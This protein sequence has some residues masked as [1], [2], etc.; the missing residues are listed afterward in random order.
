MIAIVVALG[1]NESFGGLQEHLAVPLLPL[2]DKPF[3]QHVVEFVANHEVRDFHFILSHLPEKIEEALGDGVRWGCKFRYHLLPG[4]GDPLRLAANIA[5]TQQGAV[6]LATAEC[7]PDFDLPNT[8][9]GTRIA[10]EGTWTRWAVLDPAQFGQPG[11]DELPSVEAGAFLSIESGRDFLR[12]Q[13]VA[14]ELQFPGLLIAGRQADPGVW[15]ARNVVMHPTAKVTPPVYIGENCRIGRG[16][17]LGPSAVIGQNCIIDEHT[18]VVDSMV[19]AGTYVGEGLELDAV[20]V[21]RNRLLNTRLETTLLASEA[22]LLGS[23]TGQAKGRD[24]Y[25]IVSFV[26]ALALLLIFFP[27]LL[28]TVACA[29]LGRKGALASKRAVTIPADEDPASWRET[30]VPVFH[31]PV[32]STK[33]ISVRA[34]LFFCQLLPG[35]FAVLQGKLFLVGVQPRSKEEVLALPSDWRSLYLR[36]KSG[37]ITESAVMFGDKPSED[38]L[39]T[40]E[41]VY[42]ATES[43]SH[44]LRLLGLWFS[45]LVVGFPSSDAGGM[46][47]GQVEDLN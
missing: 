32:F 8:P 30:S 31:G 44:D 15:I 17:Q 39:Y 22:F 43:I 4:D 10:H 11:F 12:S 38:E 42:S 35:L 19:A 20:I 45:K 36:T 6:L 41:A 25:R 14:L 18:I 24:T 27:L 47:S 1:S 13:R 33:G 7:L 21:D 2:A 3:I 37:I 23:L 26:I 9:P 40:A 16:A 29:I 34:G 28:V 46:D 5:G